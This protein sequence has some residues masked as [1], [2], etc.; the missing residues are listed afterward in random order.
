MA[1]FG[2]SRRT[3][4]R[5]DVERHSAQLVVIAP[6]TPGSYSMASG[7]RA[8]R[9]PQLRDLAFDRANVGSRRPRWLLPLHYEPSPAGNWSG[10]AVLLPLRMRTLMRFRRAM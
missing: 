9:F 1:A 3:T 6:L 7:S 8:S 4:C 5:V 10:N 2:S